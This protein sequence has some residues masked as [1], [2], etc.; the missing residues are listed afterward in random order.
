MKFSIEDFCTF[1]KANHPSVFEE[2]VE[3]INLNIRSLHSPLCDFYPYL[4]VAFKILNRE[5]TR[6]E[7]SCLLCE[8]KDL[9]CYLSKVFNGRGGFSAFSFRPFDP[10]KDGIDTLLFEYIFHKL[11]FE[12]E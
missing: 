4:K 2:G 7:L 10:D 9:K 6:F 8:E 1:L 11:N 5:E 3:E 12:G